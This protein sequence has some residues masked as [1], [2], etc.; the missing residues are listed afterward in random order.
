MARNVKHSGKVDGGSAIHGGEPFGTTF[1]KSTTHAPEL[2]KGVSRGKDSG[3]IGVNG[4]VPQAQGP[5]FTCNDSAISFPSKM[6]A[7]RHSKV[8]NE[9]SGHGMDPPDTVKSGGEQ[10]GGRTGYGLKKAYEKSG[11]EDSKR[12][13][14]F[15]K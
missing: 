13:S 9:K 11:R 7:E 14:A 15:G 10:G 2:R 5:T 8:I 3:K 4:V 6:A 1:Q 12:A